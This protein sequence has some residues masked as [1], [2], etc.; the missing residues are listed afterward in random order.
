[1]QTC[2]PIFPV[3]LV[4]LMPLVSGQAWSA[5]VDLTLNVPG[6]L[7]YANSYA[8]PSTTPFHDDYR[9]SVPDASLDSVAIALNLSN[10][11]GID[12]LQ[13]RI[14][15]A[16]Q[17]GNPNVLLTGSTTDPLNIAGTTGTAAII[18]PI[19]LPAGQY[20]LE[21]SGQVKGLA[22]GSYSGVLNAAP[23]PVPAAAILF[24]SGL[25]GLL[26]IARRTRHTA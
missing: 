17:N 16:N 23:I 10:L 14:F 7:T 21:I 25:L 11:L 1:M 3:V 26:G 2:K 15:S 24:G 5:L 20:I 22:G 8:S 13:G 19:D 12:G 4:A 18:S 6:S 9:F